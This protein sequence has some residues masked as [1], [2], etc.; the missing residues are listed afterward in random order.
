MNNTLTE[1]KGIVVS[2]LFCCGKTYLCN[3]CTKYKCIDLDT[4]LNNASPNVYVNEIKKY[5]PQYDF[6]FIAP[7]PNVL[8]KLQKECLPYVSVFP[9]HNH[10]NYEEWR[11]RCMRRDS[12]RLHLSVLFNIMVCDMLKDK[13]AAAKYILNRTEYLSDIID[14]IYEDFHK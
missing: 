7:R 3:T 6:I 4:I 12:D 14:K 2:A 13:H 10:D 1:S 8:R 9:K 11:S 5:L